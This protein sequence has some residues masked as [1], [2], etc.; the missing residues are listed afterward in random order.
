MDDAEVIDF[1]K[2]GEFSFRV[3]GQENFVGLQFREDGSLVYN[4]LIPEAREE[5]GPEATRQRLRE[6]DESCQAFRKV[7]A[8]LGAMG[9]PLQLTKERPADEA[10]LLQAPAALRSAAKEGRRRRSRRTEAQVRNVSRMGR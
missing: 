2:Q 10:A 4:F 1:E 7:I 6:M 5:L 8:N 3:P 9:V